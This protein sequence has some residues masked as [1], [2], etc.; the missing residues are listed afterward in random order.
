MQAQWHGAGSVALIKPMERRLICVLLAGMISAQR[1]IQ[2]N[3]TNHISLVGPIDADTPFVVH[4]QL[5]VMASYPQYMLI[6]SPGGIVS[7]GLDVLTIAR[8]IPNLTCVAL[9]AY[10]MAFAILQSCAHRAVLDTGSLMQHQIHF[11][12]FGLTGDLRRINEMAGFVQRQSSWIAS[13]QARRIGVSRAWFENR[14]RDEW[15]L[16]GH[17]AVEHRCADETVSYISC[18]PS[19]NISSC[20]LYSN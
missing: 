3:E 16:H 11:G 20:P 10:S 1:H 17:E 12:G 18:A 7:S 4:S 2:L 5:H 9:R 8:S 13:L 19:I 14:T 15:W 6:D